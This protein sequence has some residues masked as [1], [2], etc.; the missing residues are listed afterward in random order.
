MKSKTF[1][2]EKR[3]I[4]SLALTFASM[5]I[6]SRIGILGGFNIGFSVSCAVALTV[7]FV[8]AWKK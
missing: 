5:F 8:Y 7:G 2:V 1:P 3:D 6:L 4:I